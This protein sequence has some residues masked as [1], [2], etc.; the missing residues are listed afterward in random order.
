MPMFSHVLVFVVG[1]A[2][3]PCSSVGLWNDLVIAG[4]GSGHLRVFSATNG[5]MCV[6]AAAHAKWVTSVDVAKSSG[7]VRLYVLLPIQV[8]G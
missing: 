2:S 8:F 6:E 1:A 3:S 7:L 5:K 4:Y